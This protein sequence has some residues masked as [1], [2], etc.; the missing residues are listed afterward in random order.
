MAINSLLIKLIR[1]SFV[2][3]Y[4]IYE[5]EVYVLIVIIYVFSI[6]IS[7]DIKTLN[8]NKISS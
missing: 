8:N 4:Y 1:S 2:Y 3:T 7:L 5:C 6:I